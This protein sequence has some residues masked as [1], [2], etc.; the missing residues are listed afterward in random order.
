MI[1]PPELISVMKGSFSEFHIRLLRKAPGALMMALA[2][3]RFRTL[4]TVPRTYLNSFIK[5]TKCRSFRSPD[6][7]SDR[8]AGMVLGSSHPTSHISSSAA[9]SS[10]GSALF[11]LSRS[12]RDFS[13]G[14]TPFSSSRRQP[15]LRRPFSIQTRLVKS[16]KHSAINASSSRSSVG[17]RRSTKVVMPNPSNKISRSFSVASP[18]R[19][20][21]KSRPGIIGDDLVADR[22]RQFF[23]F[24]RG[25]FRS[26]HKARSSSL[27]NFVSSSSSTSTS[28]LS[29]TFEHSAPR[30]AFAIAALL[31]L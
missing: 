15:S 3:S 17:D 11:L 31:L 20:V 9:I 6:L 4:V 8:S 26:M 16:S 21:R 27:Y 7:V 29:S 10:A 24:S 12:F 19:P 14:D 18:K 1:N 25:R 13:T 23:T 30:R 2:M 28:F 22:S 5:D